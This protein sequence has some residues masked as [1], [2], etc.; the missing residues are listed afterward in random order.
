MIYFATD[1][2][3]LKKKH[4][5]IFLQ[6]VPSFQIPT[7]LQE[8]YQTPASIAADIIYTAYCHNDIK[9]KH[10]VDLGCGTGIFSFGAAYAAASKI[11]GI[12]IDK[13]CID[14]AKAFAKQHSLSVTFLCQDVSSVD[15]TGDVV[16]MNPPFGAQK[17]NIHADRVFIEKA[18]M[19][20]PVI[21]SLHLSKTLPFLTK[22]IDSLHGEITFQKTYEFPLK[23]SFSFHKK[24]L[25][26]ID[27]TLL[28]ILHG[29]DLA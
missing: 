5:E 13:H 17:A 15:L 25:L 10:V 3:P 1:M 20:A 24:L 22:L 19:V 29:P 9:G 26:N 28:R 18:F 6:Q 4:L 23:G 7:V 14:I 27:V 8:Q 11:S 16:V 2:M 21:Y 12:D